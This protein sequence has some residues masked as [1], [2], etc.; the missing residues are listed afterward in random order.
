MCAGWVE[1][2]AQCER[3]ESASAVKNQL[4]LFLTVCRCSI[5]RTHLYSDWVRIMLSVSYNL[6]YCMQ[7]GPYW[8]SH[9]AAYKKGSAQAYTDNPL[10]KQRPAGSSNEY[11]TPHKS[12]AL[13]RHPASALSR[14]RQWG[15]RAALMM[16][17]HGGSGFQR[18]LSLRLSYSVRQTL[19]LLF[20]LCPSLPL[21]DRHNTWVSCA[22]GGRA[23]HQWSE[24]EQGVTGRESHVS[25]RRKQP[26]DPHRTSG[27]FRRTWA[28]AFIRHS[29]TQVVVMQYIYFVAHNY[30]FYSVLYSMF[31]KHC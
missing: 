5:V 8:L 10:R 21:G 20:F 11:K 15:R 25:D 27:V 23:Q 12:R 16:G 14:R 26:T 31:P 9:G 13:A 1:E 3:N 4:C 29:F 19:L 17:N 6:E 18:C 22:L 28:T 24:W 30:V 2:K 7:N